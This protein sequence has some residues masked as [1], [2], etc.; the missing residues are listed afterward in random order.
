MPATKSVELSLLD[1]SSAK[2]R[3]WY[4]AYFPRTPHYWFAH[5]WKQ[6]FRHVELTRPLQYGPNPADVMWL[7]LLP[8]FENLDVEVS[9]DPRPPWVKV[10]EARIQKVT[11]TIRTPSVRSWF[12]IGP[13]SCVELAKYAL[14][15]NAFTV[16]TPYQLWKY[17]QKRNGV[18]VS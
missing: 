17:I 4:V 9:Y 11:T 1:T 7:N 13:P 6:G 15:I 16:R 8:T 2:T 18:L 10:P 5:T 14:G 12:D 3:T